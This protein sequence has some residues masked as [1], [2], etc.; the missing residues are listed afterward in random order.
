MKTATSEIKNTLDKTDRPAITKEKN[1]E[2]NIIAIQIT[3][4]ETHRKKMTG[5]IFP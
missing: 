2:S 3:Q 4:N 1:S 5:L